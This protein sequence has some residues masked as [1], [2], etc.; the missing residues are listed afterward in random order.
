MSIFLVNNQIV[1]ENTPFLTLNSRGY[2]YGDGFFESCKF[3]DGRILHLPMH[4]HRIRKSSML[5]KMNLPI[6][7]S[8]DE[9]ELSVAKACAENLISNARIRFSILRD[10]EGYY[11]PNE[12]KTLL[13]TEI[14]PV[15][16]IGNYQWNEA[17][18]R[19]GTYK[20]LVKNSNYTSML[21]TCSSVIYTMAGLYAQEK[22]LDDVVIFNEFGRPCELVSSNIFV[23]KGEF[24]LTPPISEYCV[25]GVMRKVVMQLAEAYGYNIQERPITEVELSA[26]EEIFSTSATKGIQ[27]IADYQGKQLKSVVSKVLFGKLIKTV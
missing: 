26:A 3:A 2:R 24:L 12:N 19:I 4:G 23:V 8:A 5:L 22:G 1:K 16:Y 18:L 11:T 25:D 10:S 13:I 21:K 17:G 20:E 14:T 15:N 7:W 27:W 9:W 6:N